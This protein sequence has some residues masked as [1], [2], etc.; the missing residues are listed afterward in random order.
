MASADWAMALVTYKLAPSV[1]S[2]TRADPNPTSASSV[3]FTVTF[4]EPVFE[5]VAGEF[6]LTTTGVSGAS[7]TGISGSGTTF[8]V[9]VNTGTGS[10]TIRLDVSDHDCIVDINNRPLGGAGNGNG[11]FTTGEVYNIDRTGPDV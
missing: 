4:N 9:T 7:I 10:G 2:I 1:L 5:V 11:N 3:D 8:T 6:A